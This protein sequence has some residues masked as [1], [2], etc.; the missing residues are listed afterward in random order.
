M[1]LAKNLMNLI[2]PEEEENEYEEEEENIS[3]Y[4]QP[5]NKTIRKIPVKAEMNLYDIRVFDETEEIANQLKM[6]KAAI[7]N[8]HKL[9]NEYK[10]RTIDFLSG[11]I[12][13]L[14]GTILR[15]EKNVILCSPSN[16]PING[17]IN[18]DK[19]DVE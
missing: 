2:A 16:I 14:D 11:V 7:V 3:T 6:N 1:K 12:C 9:D 18:F 17:E 19:E 8:M 10:Q 13:G 4:E 5:L 15:I